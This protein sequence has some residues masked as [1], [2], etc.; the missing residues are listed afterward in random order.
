MHVLQGLAELAAVP[1]GAALTV[2]NFD[3]I[4]VGHLAIV[5]RLHG[6]SAR[7]VVTFEPH[8]VTRL[9]PELAPPRLASAERRRELLAA[10][11]VTH[12]VELPP[13]D[14]VLALSA[15]AFFDRIMADVAPSL[16][17]EGHDFRFGQGAAGVVAALQQW[18]EATPTRVELVEPAMVRLPTLHVVPA[19]SSLTRWLISH[20]RLQEAAA[21]L[22]RPHAVPGIVEKGHQRGRTLGFPTANLR[23]D[24]AFCVPVDGVYAGHVTIDGVDKP[25]AI[26][27]GTN[28]TFNDRRRTIEAHLLDFDEDLYGRDIAVA[29][30][31]WLRPQAR[32]DGPDALVEQLH[33]D[34]AATRAA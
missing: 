10:A 23:H 14:E 30:T 21:V 6:A 34:V 33:R 32:Y 17:I 20:G 31:R 26:S 27:V 29:F 1:D 18:T 13:V 24:A 3:G 2:G 5:E 15:R 25:A 19:S 22:G 12:L 4:H 11:G 7:C 9:R 8:P 28:P 16:W